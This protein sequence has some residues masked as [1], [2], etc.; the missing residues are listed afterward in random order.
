MRARL[1]NIEFKSTTAHKALY[2]HGI[3][4]MIGWRNSTVYGTARPL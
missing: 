4:L 3:I 2:I 1:I